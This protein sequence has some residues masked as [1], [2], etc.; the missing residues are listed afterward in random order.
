MSLSQG[1]AD[2]RQ[3]AQ[4]PPPYF[5]DFLFE[6]AANAFININGIAAAVSMVSSTVN[7]QGGH[8]GQAVATTGTGSTGTAALTLSVAG[9]NALRF[10]YGE[11][12]LETVLYVET[13]SDGVDTF[14]VRAGYNNA[15]AGDGTDGIMFR[16]TDTVNG[17]RW[18]CVTRNNNV[19]AIID[20]TVPVVAGTWYKLHINVNHAADEVQ[21]YINGVLVA[22]Q[23]DA[24]IPTNR[25]SYQY[26]GIL[27]S[28]GAN[29]RRLVIDYVFHQ[30]KLTNSR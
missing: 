14:S 1:I 12:D 2:V 16:Y 25:T 24:T 22:T 4:T 5:N 6:G 8:P 28:L 7:D 30:I 9:T 29:Q 20:S 23:T 27:K 10:G 17:G 26:I 3:A 18:Q 19:E 13:L 11:L 15:F 21:F